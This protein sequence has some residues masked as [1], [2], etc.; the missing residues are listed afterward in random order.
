[1]RSRLAALLVVLGL[2]LALVPAGASHAAIQVDH[3]G[4]WLTDRFGRIVILHGVNMVDKLPPYDPASLGFGADDATL[5]QSAGFNT[6]RLGV[7]LKAIEPTKGHFDEAYLASIQRTADML[8]RHGM[9]VVLDFHQDLYNERFNGE[10]FPDWMVQ[11]DGLPAE[12]D[13]GFP[14]NYFAMP[15]LWRAFD[16]L[17]ANDGGLQDDFAAAWQH[18]AA[19]F[20]NDPAI[21]GYDTFNEPWPGSDWET[22]LQPAGCPLFDQMTLTP[23]FTKVFHAIREADTRHLVFYEPNPET[24]GTGSQVWI[25]DTGDPNAGLSFHFYCST[26]WAGR[27]SSALCGARPA[28]TGRSTSRIRS[29]RATATLCCSRSSARRTTSRTSR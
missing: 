4:R 19:R 9:R 1:M 16:H 8:G 10:G 11:D 2:G 14:A 24:A 12:P 27:A 18:V 6:V 15:A 22:C 5:L 20:A 13:F 3:K 23:F 7:I 21:L 26:R 29:P 25:G 17:W 28:R